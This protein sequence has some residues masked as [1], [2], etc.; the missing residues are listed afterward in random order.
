MFELQPARTETHSQ[1]DPKVFQLRVYDLIASSHR[2]WVRGRVVSPLPAQ[3]QK[4]WWGSRRGREEVIPRQAKLECQ[5]GSQTLLADVVIGSG[6]D[7]ETTISIVLPPTR[8]GWRIA[9]NKLTWNGRE[10]EA[11]SV[12][13]PAPRGPAP[14]AVVILPRETPHQMEISPHACSRAAELH[15]LV[16]GANPCQAIYYLASMQALGEST[17]AELALAAT[18]MGWPR[19]QFVLLPGRPDEAV[20]AGVDRFRWL[21]TEAQELVVHEL[22]GREMPA[23]PS[24]CARLRQARSGLVTRYPLV[25]CHGM[26]A[27]SMLRMQMPRER[28]YFAALRNFLDE[29]GFRSLF[30]LVNPT[31][32]VAERGRQL[33]EQIRQWTEEPVNLIAHSMGG[34]D[35]R[36]L[37]SRLG[38]AS[39]VRSLTTVGTPHHGS[40][41][42][43]WFLANYRR[44]VPLLVAFEALGISMEGFSDC[45]PE[46]CREFNRT[47]P[48]MPGV[49][50]F[51]YG[52]D[53]SPARL[54]PILRRAWNLLSAL[55]GPNDGLVS[56]QS[57]RWG[58]YLGTLAADHFAQTP[59]GLF[60]RQGENFDSLG[61]FTRL[62]TDLARR[63]F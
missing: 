50:Y 3:P 29:R 38:M 35:A 12:V 28:N 26:L 32:S 13:L 61:F 56:V 55:E 19:G 63:G 46:V 1:A 24:S 27:C 41:L 8:R 31:G 45:R 57:A 53:V 48:D 5:I 25:F 49:H 62:V 9:R 59:D 37:I 7:W 4:Y 30:P 6:G 34:L 58:T 47:T 2:L 44:R 20:Q 33:A 14:V 40:G 60:V 36:Y 17:Q 10:A 23:S 22:D 51:S 15:R 54:A 52:G 43:D 11:C 18:A 21:F 39:Q 16:Q 42:A